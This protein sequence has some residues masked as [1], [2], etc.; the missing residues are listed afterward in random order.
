M[1]LHATTVVVSVNVSGVMVS[2]NVATSVMNSL[3]VRLF[4]LFR[5]TLQVHYS[6]DIVY[7]VSFSFCLV[8]KIY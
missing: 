5:V 6:R 3:A 1:R 2:I 4:I 7:C 8:V